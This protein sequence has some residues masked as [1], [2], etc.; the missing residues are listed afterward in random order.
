MRLSGLVFACL[1][2]F[3]LSTGSLESLET[4]PGV[5][6]A[7]LRMVFL[8]PLV[9]SIAAVLGIWI[10]ALYLHEQAEIAHEVEREQALMERMYRHDIE[11]NAQMLNAAMNIILRDAALRQALAHRDRDQLLRLAL[12]L[13]EMLRRKFEITHF[14]FSGPDR[15]NILR[16]H[17]P[18][19]HG[20]VINRYTTLQA[21]R[22]GKTSYGVELGTLGTFTLRLVTPWY[23]GSKLIGYVELGMEIDHV[24]RTVR[25]FTDVP[26]FMLIDKQYVHRR[27]WEEGMRMLGRSPEWDAFPNFV[28]GSQSVD[29]M[30]DELVKQLAQEKQLAAP[31][32]SEIRQGGVAYQVIQ[33]PLSDAAG[34]KVGRMVSLID[35]SSNIASLRKSLYQGTTV[36]LVIAVLLITIFYHLLQRI[37][38]RIERGDQTLKRMATHDGLTGLFNHRMFH[39][40][41][42]EEI[43]RARRFNHPVSLLMIDIDNFKGVN[44]S[45]GHQAGDT[46]LRG[47]SNLLNREVRAVDRVCRYGGEE[48]VVV[49]PETELGGAAVMAEQLRAKVEELSFDLG[50]AHPLHVTVSI[51]LATWPLHA[52]DALE[53][54]AAAD[55]A[56]YRAKQ[57]GKNRVARYDDPI[58]P[59]AGS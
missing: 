46:I 59:P 44:D 42:N 9:A 43:L 16:V 17:R 56:M 47:I 20:D 39:V 52:G 50:T 55:A 25:A 57:S 19:R 8:V 37:G 22:T 3:W 54:V 29:A 58:A 15:V 11:R 5:K 18:E 2:N 51:G 13:N 34:R 14:Y 12:P 38:Q 36:G 35:V 40:L 4:A 48:M 10:A 28:L 53:L 21:E 31:V 27:R 33:V 1:K 32:E 30:P 24:L 26:V 23:E 6:T 7:C 49:L 45:Y 41:L